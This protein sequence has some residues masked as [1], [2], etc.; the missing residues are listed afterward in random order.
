MLSG[1]VE[2]HGEIA[3]W[4]FSEGLVKKWLLDDNAGGAFSWADPFQ[5]VTII[6]VLPSSYWKRQSRKGRYNH[7]YKYTYRYTDKYTYKYNY[8]LDSSKLCEFCI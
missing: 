3:R 6:K 4:S 5:V 1:L 2:V 8:K 7:I